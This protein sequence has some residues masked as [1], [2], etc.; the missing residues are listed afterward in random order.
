MKEEMTRR[1]FLGV[2]SG[3]LA[4]AGGAMAGN[5]LG[6]ASAPSQAFAIEAEATEETASAGTPN[7]V[8][9]SAKLTGPAVSDKFTNE[10][11]DAMI[12]AE[13]DVQGDYIAPDGTVVPEIYLRLRNR[14]N[15]IGYG[16]GS[17][18]EGNGTEWDFMKIMFSEED[19]EHYLEMPMYR[20]FNATD[21]AA[22]SGRS[23]EEA[24]EILNDMSKR[25]LVCTRYKGGVPYYHLLTSEWGIWEYNLDRYEEPGFLE[26]WANR[27]GTDMKIEIND[28][29][30]PQLLVNPVSR[31]I[32]DGDPLPYTDWEAMFRRN[33]YIAVAPC[34]CRKAR[35]IL[36]KEQEEWEQAPD[37]AESHP[38]DTCMIFGDVAKYYIERGEGRQLTVD[39]AIALEKEIIDAGMVP[40]C[41]WTK[42]VDFMCNCSGDCCLILSE[43]VEANGAGNV[44]P[45][46][47][48][49]DLQ[50]DQDVCLKCGACVERC[51][52]GAITMDEEGEGFCIMDMKCVRCG[53]CALVCPVGARSLKP[54][55][56]EEMMELPEDM[57]SDYLDEA[58]RRMASGLL[59]D[60]DQ[61]GQVEPQVA[62]YETEDG[63]TLA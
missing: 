1:N 29:V 20:M 12:L 6:A 44:M 39:E 41:Q 4:A 60:F 46:V 24:T 5:A 61:N 9:E 43:Y 11:L 54:R 30:R 23:V 51:P 32:I 33:E 17:E 59:F 18:I 27:A 21:Y 8:M 40:E 55:P 50:Y 34:Q 14:I 62:R 16:V 22:Y 7:K 19:A 45:N 58:R 57:M 2:M 47:S 13:T 53:Q 15:R 10:E 35:S 56:F 42:Q 28:N 25:G 3:A 36:G 38:M 37:C 48:P 31:D 26:A 63:F 49:Y 52:M